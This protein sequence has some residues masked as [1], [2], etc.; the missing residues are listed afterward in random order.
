MICVLFVICIYVRAPWENS[1]C[2]L[3]G[4]PYE[5]IN[6]NNNNYGDTTSIHQDT[7]TMALVYN[8]TNVKMLHMKIR[9]PH[10]RYVKVCDYLHCAQ[11]IKYIITFLI[12][13]IHNLVAVMS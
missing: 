4:L 1:S 5:F 7:K 3:N 10:K 13:S 12:M 2:E 11:I 8:T 9:H 6:N